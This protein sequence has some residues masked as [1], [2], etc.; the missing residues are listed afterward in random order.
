MNSR[1]LAAAEESWRHES[2]QVN[3]IRLHYVR[4]GQGTPLVLVHGWPEF[5][6][7]WRKILPLLARSHDVIAYDLRGFGASEKP[8]GEAL[9]S[10]TL[11]HH[12]QDLSALI[13]ALDL[14]DVGLVSHDSGANIAQ[15]Y[16]RLHPERLRGLFFFDCPYPGIGKRWGDAKVIRESW[17]QYFNQLPWTAQWLTERRENCERYLRYC[18]DHWC[19][20]PG[21]FDSDLDAWVDNYMEPGNMQ[22]GFNWYKAMQPF[23]EGL[24]RDGAPAMP[25]IRV[26]ARVRWGASDPVLLPEFADRLGDYFSDVDFKVVEGAGHFVAFEKPDYAAAEILDFFGGLRGAAS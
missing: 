15:G 25:I 24:I 6:R 16:A 2:V 22:G 26:P 1:P 10:Y 21:T 9:E 8:P 5:W 7:V 3:G 19:H 4:Q 17:Y 13:D 23:R 14:R 20:A 11:E 12:I 18:L